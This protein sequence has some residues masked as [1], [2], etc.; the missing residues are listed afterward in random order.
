MRTKKLLRTGITLIALLALFS[1]KVAAQYQGSDTYQVYENGQWVIKYYYYDAHDVDKLLGIKAA[2]PQS[3]LNWSE[4]SYASWEGCSWQADNDHIKH[5]TQIATSF[6]NFNNN[7]TTLDISGCTNLQWLDCRNNQLTSLNVSGLTNLQSL[8]CMNNQLSSLNVSGCTNLL[9]LG[10]CN[11]QLTSLNVNGLSNLQTLLCYNNQLTSLNV[12]GITNLQSLDCG[13]NQLTS[14]N[15]SGLTNLQE[16]YCSFNQLT[17]LNV[18]GLTNLQE[19]WCYNNQ[20]TSLNVSGITN[21]Q[22]LDCGNNQL[23]SLNVSGITNLQTLWCEA[24]QLTSLNVSGLTNL[25]Y[26]DCSSNQLTSLNVSGLTNLQWLGCSGNQL[27]SLDVSGCTNLQRLYCHRNQLTLLNVSGLTNLQWLYCCYNQLSDE[28]LPSFYGLNIKGSDPNG[29][30]YFD[31]RG[32]QG[33]TESAIRKL[34]D[35]LPYISYE[36]ILYDKLPE[37]KITCSI[38][39]TVLEQGE[40]YNVAYKASGDYEERNR[41]LVQLSDS[42][43]S[44]DNP[45]DIT[46]LSTVYYE[47]SGIIKVN[48]PENI[49][50]GEKYRL[51]VYSTLPETFGADNGKNLTIGNAF[52]LT[53]YLT[54]YYDEKQ[55]IGENHFMFSGNLNINHSLYF[56]CPLEVEKINGVAIIKGN[57]SLFANDIKGIS[58]PISSNRT[59]YNLNGL[60]HYT[61]S[62]EYLNMILGSDNYIIGPAQLAGMWTNIGNIEFDKSEKKDWIRMEY[63]IID[64]PVFPLQNIIDYYLEQDS[65]NPNLS[66]EEKEYSKYMPPKLKGIVYYSHSE[67]HEYAFDVALSNISLPF[68]KINKFNLKYDPVQDEY[69]GGL[70]VTI[71]KNKSQIIEFE[72]ERDFTMGFD[73]SYKQGRI[74]IMASNDN[75]EIPIYASGLAITKLAADIAY[76][77]I[78]NYFEL[79]MYVDIAPVGDKKTKGLTSAIIEGKDIGFH[80]KTPPLNLALTGKLALFKQEVADA[81]IEYGGVKS[82]LP[83]VILAERY[84]LTGNINVMDIFHA[85][86]DAN[87]T[88]DLLWGQAYGY[89]QAPQWTTKYDILSSLAGKKFTNIAANWYGWAFDF[90]LEKDFIVKKIKLNCAAVYTEDKGF[91]WYWGKTLKN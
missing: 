17:S 57:G 35:N 33:F 80:L 43:D 40:S 4:N 91:E 27:T 37:A 87:F 71:T 25:Q 36:Q 55:T 51:R 7:L 1:V 50:G 45:T 12:S 44:F 73:L 8:D 79:G 42:S 10:C 90:E 64:K 38:D 81:K 2:N 48:I 77:H 28:N 23:T 53:D 16:L 19:L 30:D 65:K 58:Y 14:L 5:L 67:G 62:G 49:P 61:A 75:V 76:N 41:F 24:N 70:T 52:K 59:G 60:L 83:P 89:I 9:S 86:L 54:L 18:S 39:A 47:T 56:D 72:E 32:N 29:I 88:S 21:L 69:R 26:L 66:N 13:Y 82:A 11:N 68:V 3:N 31:L 22:W 15:V 74:G 85:K 63:S 34:A 20:L 84:S 78:A 6:P 46:D